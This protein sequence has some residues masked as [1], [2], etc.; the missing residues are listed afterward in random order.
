M[1]I[2]KFVL[3]S[4]GTN[5][6]LLINEKDSD[7]VDSYDLCLSPGEENNVSHTVTNLKPE[8]TYEYKLYVYGSGHSEIE[9]FTTCG[10]IAEGNCGENAT[11]VLAENGHIVISG[12]GDIK[13]YST[14]ADQPWH[15]YNSDITKLTVE[16]EITGI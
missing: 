5:C 13:D 12:T 2:E 8:T 14:P 1:K 4:L 15:Q 3:G 16:G 7:V 11:W 6:Y 10:Y 9:E